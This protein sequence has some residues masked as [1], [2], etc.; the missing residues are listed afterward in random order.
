MR[1]LDFRELMFR[2]RKH[3]R[4]KILL[5]NSLI[6]L[7]CS[8]FSAFALCNDRVITAAHHDRLDIHPSAMERS[9]NAAGVR[10]RASQLPHFG[11]QLRSELRPL[12]RALCEEL[13][14]LRVLDVVRGSL[15]SVFSVTAGFDKVIQ[16]FN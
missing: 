8:I 4:R 14:E 11:L 1:S 6:V 2:Y 10:R 3:V 16:T 12:F 5:E 7:D 9:R 15:E 13:L